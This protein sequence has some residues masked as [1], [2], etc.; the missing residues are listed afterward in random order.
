M[1]VNSIKLPGQRPHKK[2][3]QQNNDTVYQNVKN[4]LNL[5]GVQESII[6]VQVMPL[7]Q[8]AGLGGVKSNKFL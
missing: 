5:I 3:N 4:C 1:T 8:E 7:W 2:A 6:L